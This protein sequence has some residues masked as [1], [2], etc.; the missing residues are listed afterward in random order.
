MFDVV[1]VTRFRDHQSFMLAQQTVAAGLHGAGRLLVVVPD[2][3]V[4]HF[5]RLSLRAAVVPES[6]LDPRLASLPSSWFKQ[7]LVKLCIRPV[8]EHD[9]ALIMDSDTYLCREVEAASFFVEGRPPFYVEDRTGRAHPAWRAGAEALLDHHSLKGWTYFPTP[10]FVHREVLAGLHEYLGELWGED[11][12]EGLCARL[13]QYTEWAT[14]GLFVDELWGDDCPQRVCDVDHVLGLWERGDF[15][16]WCPARATPAEP[17]LLVVQ[18]VIGAG[19]HET[20][21]KLRGYPLV[22]ACLDAP[23]VRIH[24]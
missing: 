12:F 20:T 8:L 9:A 13:G 3:E 23:E 17:P 22:A 14:Y 18:S 10:N 5:A 4:P 16:A 19:W 24:G 21:T 2:E 11:P 7:Q 1:F 15:D 6:C